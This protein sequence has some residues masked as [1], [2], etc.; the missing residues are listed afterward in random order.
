MALTGSLEIMPLAEVFQWVEA[1]GKSGI[2]EISHGRT[3]VQFAF[4]GGRLASCGSN[5]PPT[6]LGQFLL[7][8]GKVDEKKLHDAL[9]QQERDGGKLGTILIDM[10]LLTKQELDRFVRAK[11]EETIFRL[12][13]RP[14]AEFR[15]DPTLRPMSTAV[16]LDLD[17]TDVLMRG[18]QRQAELERMKSVFNDPG[19]VLVR[20]SHPL[21]PEVVTAPMI[22]RLYDLVDSQR[23]FAEIL[24][25]SRAPE[26]LATK[27]LFELYRR[28]VVAIKDI[29][30]VPPEPGSVEAACALA[31]RLAARGETE[32]ALEIL[33]ACQQ[34]N[35]SHEG[36][37]RALA[38]LETNYLDSIYKKELPP[39]S[40][41]I[42]R[43]CS[44]ELRDSRLSSNELFILE[45][46]KENPG[47]VKSIVR[48]APLHEIDVIVA[49]RRLAN[50]GLL[51]IREGQAE[52]QQSA[53]HVEAVLHSLSSEI[54]QSLGVLD[55]TSASPAPSVVSGNETDS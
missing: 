37:Q 39:T 24:L 53:A 51:E 16:R 34:D 6:L 42:P 26:F 1:H 33:Q 20:T 32:A 35:P 10:G 12:F 28:G 2:L 14:K 17:L 52:T 5:D 25:L 29:H 54:E 50:K 45:M 21:Q 49:M 55:G 7:A 19:M 46:I 27:F 11:A 47:D 4:E 48:I 8:H 3:Q 18:A 40:M 30:D 9:L 13:D 36:L 15:F 44:E 22:R 38:K 43:S 31:E 23:T 41:L